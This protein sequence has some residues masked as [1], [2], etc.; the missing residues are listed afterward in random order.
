MRPSEILPPVMTRLIL[1]C[2]GRS[3]IRGDYPDWRSAAAASAPYATD[4]ETY[5]RLAD[6]IRAGRASSSRTL[7]PL[8]A[9]ILLSGSSARILDF[10]GG[11]AHL[12]FE[13]VRLAPRSI[14]SWNI[15]DL[16]DVVALGNHRFADGK[17]R[18]FGTLAESAAD[19]APDI[20]LLSHTLQYLERPF[21]LLRQ[22]M[23]LG[24]SCVVLLEL[25]IAAR[26]RFV[27]QHLLAELGGGSRPARIFRQSDITSALVG[28]RLLEEIEL[29]PWDRTLAGA[30]H[31]SRL[32]LRNARSC[33]P[34]GS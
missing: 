24:P 30:R 4:L 10:G 14:T 8:L 5:A 6:A 2:L 27:I 29:Q 22:L 1:R 25:P 13:V 33:S 28:Y 31:V 32:Y 18:F 26:E 15:V 20:V 12:Y 21:E 16:P 19:G 7:S 3:T 34:P 17:L 23:E 9:A 11:L